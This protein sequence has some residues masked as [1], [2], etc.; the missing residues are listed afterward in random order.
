MNE[1]RKLGPTVL[2]HDLNT[3]WNIPEKFRKLGQ[4]H[5]RYHQQMQIF[6]KY[7]EVVTKHLLGINLVVL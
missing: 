3:M 6:S 2:S 7:A 5:Y 4:I 1:I